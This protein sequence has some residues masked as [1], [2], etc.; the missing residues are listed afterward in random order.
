M[1]RGEALAVLLFSASATEYVL[2]F[3][4][5]DINLFFLLYHHRSNIPT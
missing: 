3:Q 5:V 1:R 2:W 4:E